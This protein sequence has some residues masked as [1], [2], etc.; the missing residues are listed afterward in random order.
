MVAANDWTIDKTAVATGLKPELLRQFL[1]LFAAK[2]KTVTIFSMGVNQS[3]SGTDKVNAIINCH[4][5]TGRIGK[6]GAGPFSITGQPNAMGGREVGG[7]ATMLAAHMDFDNAEHRNA[8]Q[9]HWQSPTIAP[10]PG[11]K[12]VDMFEAVGDGRIKALW[13]I[14]T[15][16][17]VSMPHSTAIADALKACPFVVVSDI[18]ANTGTVAYADIFL[19][20]AGWGEKDGTVTNSE[21]RISRQ[22]AFLPKPGAARADW[23][24]ICDVAIAMS[25]A[26]F[27]YTSPAEIFS[28]HVALTQKLNKG[29]RKLDLSAWQDRDYDALEP[30][31][32]GGA[33][34][35]AD[36]RFQTPDGKAR[37]VATPFK[38]AS[39]QGLTLNTGRMRD[40]WHTM[41]RTGL[42]PRLFGHRAE[43]YVEIH[44][45]DA[46]R[47]AI[48]P[49]S[50]IEV[51][52]EGGKSIARALISGAVKQ[53]DIFNPCIGV[54][55]L[56]RRHWS[57]RARRLQLIQ[58][59]ANP[60]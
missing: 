31:Q 6:E 26:G 38:S 29:S 5:L 42:V 14:S 9:E 52:N 21:R 48:A 55:N 13:I 51:S 60:P 44:P 20:A 59:A 30:R 12:A 3:A 11:L 1:D 54:E 23:Q 4:L 50:L 2:S 45:A 32:W 25:F 49:A 22:R 16:P 37:F 58:S 33:R 34:P 10:K 57:T 28:E 24:I 7:L 41:T 18:T 39:R 8:V 17:A 56:Q 40:Q 35:F 27:D 43:P 15:N 47:L 19:P 46:K 36:F 53:G